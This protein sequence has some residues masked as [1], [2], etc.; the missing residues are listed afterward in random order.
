MGLRIF[1]PVKCFNQPNIRAGF[2]VTF[3]EMSFGLASRVGC[4]PRRFWAANFLPRVE[5][6]RMEA[7]VSCRSSLCASNAIFRN[8]IRTPPSRSP[9]RRNHIVRLF[10]EPVS[11]ICEKHDPEQGFRPACARCGQQNYLQPFRPRS[12]SIE[13]LQDPLR[14]IASLLACRKLK[15]HSLALGSHPACRHASHSTEGTDSEKS[16]ASAS[17]PRP[18]SAPSPRL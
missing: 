9:R 18:Q 8:L 2:Q 7:S 11:V 17:K 14:G 10:Q 12:S 3:T 1:L 6:D 16:W 5:G 15:I 4:S 13:R